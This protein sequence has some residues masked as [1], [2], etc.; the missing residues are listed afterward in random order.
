MSIFFTVGP[1]LDEFTKAA[2]QQSEG[3]RNGTSRQ[4]QASR[5]GTSL[6]S[7]A[8]RNRTPRQSQASRN[9]SKRQKRKLVS[10]NA[11]RE[12]SS[13][14]SG[15]SQS[16]GSQ[17]SSG[18][19]CSIKSYFSPS[20]KKPSSPDKLLKKTSDKELE[21]FDPVLKLLVMSDSDSDASM[22][23]DINRGLKAEEDETDGC[24]TGD[25]EDEPLQQDLSE[26]EAEGDTATDRQE[27]DRVS[28]NGGG[29]FV[30]EAGTEEVLSDTGL[31]EIADSLLSVDVA[32]SDSGALRLDQTPRVTHLV[33]PSIP[34]TAFS[35]PRQTSLFSFFRPHCH[36][37][38]APKK[39]VLSVAETVPGPS[40]PKQGLGKSQISS[41]TA[42]KAPLVK[43]ASETVTLLRVPSPP[44]PYV[45]VKNVHPAGNAKPPAMRGRPSTASASTSWQ[46]S[47][48]RQCPFYKQLPGM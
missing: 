12:R 4:S 30:P 46:K 7:Q 6:Q 29:G 9:R 27:V 23:Q 48:G 16:Q 33:N 20:G 19:T 2:S 39:H 44:P 1:I 25:W 5:N 41:H 35:V 14:E 37:A 21:D 43:S 45:Q 38:G 28:E 26:A 24:D 8:S 3:S 42:D 10:P 13:R 36:S 11:A 31:M 32:C 40:L 34:V 17:S 22:D 18:L 15:P 47:S